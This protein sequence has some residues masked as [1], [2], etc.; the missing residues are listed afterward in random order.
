MSFRMASIVPSTLASARRSS[1]GPSSPLAERT[2]RP[3]GLG[4]RS[5]EF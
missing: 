4:E 2:N 3:N 5:A 1:T